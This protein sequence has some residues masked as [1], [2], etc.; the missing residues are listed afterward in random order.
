MIHTIKFIDFS[1][2][3]KMKDQIRS[4]IEESIETKKKVNE[5]ILKDI[6][7]AAKL[8]ISTIKSGKKIMLAGNGGSASQ[9]SH[10][11]AEFVGRYKIERKGLPAIAL[12]TDL[13]AITAIGNDYGFERIFERQLE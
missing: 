3:T 9:A 5:F 12:A 1:K 11:A 6:E 7:S 2:V 13:A 10:I 4:M 8:V